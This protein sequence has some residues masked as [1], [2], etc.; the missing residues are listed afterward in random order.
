MLLNILEAGPRILVPSAIIFNL[1]VSRL[2][3]FR[4]LCHWL[5]QPVSQML[6]FAAIILDVVS[7]PGFACGE[8]I[9]HVFSVICCSGFFF[10]AN[11]TRGLCWPQYYSSQLEMQLDTNSFASMKFGS[12]RFSWGNFIRLLL[13]KQW[14]FYFIF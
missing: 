5:F 2:K 11:V 1:A 10:W 7:C 13:M 12:L 4:G 8:T 6:A 14:H 9:F 3:P